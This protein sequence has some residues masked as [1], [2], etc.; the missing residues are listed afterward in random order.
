MSNNCR[1][2]FYVTITIGHLLIC[3]DYTLLWQH[4][5]SVM[6]YTHVSFLLL[7]YCYL[8]L[9]VIVTVEIAVTLSDN[10]VIEL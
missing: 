1:L 5:C 6:S 3:D 2:G 8:D 10:L 4:V 7:I 9:V